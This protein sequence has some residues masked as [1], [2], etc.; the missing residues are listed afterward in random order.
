MAQLSR[1]LQEKPSSHLVASWIEWYRRTPILVS[2]SIMDAV[3]AGELSKPLDRSGFRAMPRLRVEDVVFGEELLSANDAGI[4]SIEAFGKSG[5]L[6]ARELACLSADPRKKDD[7]EPANPECGFAF[8]VARDMLSEAKERCDSRGYSSELAWADEFA[9]NVRRD[10]PL[11]NDRKHRRSLAYLDSAATAQRPASVLQAMEDFDKHENANVYRGAY[12]LSMQATASFN[13]ARQAV[14]EYLGASRRE[15]VFTRNTTESINL[16]ALSWGSHNIERGDVIVTTLAE[17]H[18]NYLPWLLLSQRVGAHVELV[19]LSSDGSIDEADYERALA[20]KPKLVALSQMSNVIGVENPL[21]RLVKR[22]KSV[23]ARVLIDAAQGLPHCG[24]R[25]DELDADWVAFSGDKIYGPMG[26]GCLWISADA[27]NEMDP[28]MSGGGSISHVG[29][30]SYYL[31]PLAIQYEA[32]TPAISQAI[33]LAEAIRY[34]KGLGPNNICRHE[35]VMTRYL[36]DGLRSIEGVTVWG[37]H[38]AQEGL[39]GLVSFTVEGVKPI[40]VSKFLASLGVAIR[41]GGHCALPLH[42]SMGLTGTCRISM[43]TGTCR[44]SMATYTTKEELDAA[45]LALRLLVRL[46]SRSR[47]L[48]EPFAREDSIRRHYAQVAAQASQC[49]IHVGEAVQ[50]YDDRIVAGLPDAAI[51]ASR[52]CGDP[53]AKA[54]LKAGE[55]VLDLGSGGGIDAIIASRLVGA[56]GHVYGLD[57]TPEM[58]ELANKNASEANAE[59]VEF[60]EGNIESI[61][62]PDNSVDVVLSN[63][64]L[65][66]SSNKRAVMLE[67]L[68]VLRPGG[69]FVVSDIVSWQAIPDSA[70]RD[71]CAIMGCTNGVS[72]REEYETFLEE[73]GFSRVNLEVKSIYTSAVLQGKAKK[74]GRLE[75]VEALKTAGVWEAVDGA[76]GSVVICAYK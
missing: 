74:K 27:F 1:R 53:V 50:L 60:I 31:R 68:R 61:P 14:E 66:F 73:L 67:A 28:V 10:F 72:T 21:D 2:R 36:M 6:S 65:N 37:D 30:G 20:L 9:Q 47:A 58:I 62:L 48:K 70:Q 41:A 42:A 4:P 32:G 16:V 43:A 25:V 34:V 15:V 40:T 3:D 76:C 51:A 5:V 12:E 29:E 39:H 64:V 69:R 38:T 7:F 52:G 33:G 18:S 35:R 19:R 46:L 71:L 22:A 24:M 17:H 44:I 57:M 56:S 55:L 49:D 63:C 45:L 11:L 13:D 23:G 75:S 59:N 8:D 54:E 26:I